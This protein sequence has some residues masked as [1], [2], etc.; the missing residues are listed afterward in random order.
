MKAASTLDQIICDPQTGQSLVR[1]NDAYYRDDGKRY[2]IRN[3]IASLVYPEDVAGSDGKW[4]RFYDR[5]AP[6]YDVVQ[7]VLGRLLLGESVAEAHCKVVAQVPI[8]VGCRLLE[9]SPGPGTFHRS[10]RERLGGEGVLVSLD[11]S[12]QMLHQCKKRG[13]AKA[14]L[15]HGNGQYLPFLDES[16]DCLFHFGGINLFNDPKRALAEFVRVVRKGGI[17]SWGDEGFS[18]HYKGGVKKRLLTALNPGYLKPM[19]PI[20]DELVEVVVREVYGGTGYLVV[21]RKK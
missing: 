15:I 4:N 7:K 5:F 17:V 14:F 18:P 13:D 10:L 20:P 16:F 19:P 9:V 21:G 6:F 8:V 1:H 3:G 11:L 12:A 2:A